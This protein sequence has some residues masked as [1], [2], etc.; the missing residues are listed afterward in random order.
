MSSFTHDAIEQQNPLTPKL[1]QQAQSSESQI[2]A[3]ENVQ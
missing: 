1:A 3:E 2:L